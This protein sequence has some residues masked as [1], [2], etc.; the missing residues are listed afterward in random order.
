[1]AGLSAGVP[2]ADCLDSYFAAPAA[3]PVTSP[4]ATASTALLGQLPPVAIVV[5]GRALT[6]LL[7]PAYL[8]FGERAPDDDDP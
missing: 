2:L 7:L 4:A 6:E 5:R 3:L 1:V 8:A